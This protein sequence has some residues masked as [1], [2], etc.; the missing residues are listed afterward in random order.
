M[1]IIR[2]CFRV[3]GLV[4]LLMGVVR[5]QEP[6]E[7]GEL[8]L[9]VRPSRLVLEVGETARFVATVRTGDESSLLNEQPTMTLAAGDFKGH[10]GNSGNS[11]LG[12]G[13]GILPDGPLFERY[14]SLVFRTLNEVSQAT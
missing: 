8:T 14:R 3:V 11:A 13:R 4:F 12:P 1:T 6:F 7:A 5:G 10:D 9:E 2:P